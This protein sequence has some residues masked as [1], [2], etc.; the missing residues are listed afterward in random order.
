[1]LAEDIQPSRLARSVHKI[2][3]LLELRPGADSALVAYAGS[4]HLVMPMTSDAAIIETVAAELNPSI[5]PKEGDS[6]AEA[7]AL[8][9]EQLESAGC[10]GSIVLITDGIDTA[11]HDVHTRTGAAPVHIL[12]V[13]GD[14]TKPLPLDS[15][16]APAI[17]RDALRKSTAAFAA[18]LTI[19][20]PD[21]RDVR[22]LSRNIT[23]SFVA[24]QQNDGDQ[25]WMD[26]GYWLTPLICL[27]TLVWFRP[28]WVVR[29]D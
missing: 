11:Q 12:A 25:R 23:T 22:K 17:D 18:T 27:I 14:Q 13:A 28:G 15:P 8:E 1:M 4:A 29:W 26:M 24:A 16:P 6:A 5:M 2:R 19:V 9:N 21:D 20:S 7:I 10:P 3:D